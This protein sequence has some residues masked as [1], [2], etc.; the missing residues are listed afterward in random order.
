MIFLPTDKLISFIGILM[1]NGYHPKIKF[2][3]KTRYLCLHQ[4]IKIHKRLLK[5]QKKY[6]HFT[7]YWIKDKEN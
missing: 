2:E 5:I 1:Y 3:A 6:K 4:D 7:D